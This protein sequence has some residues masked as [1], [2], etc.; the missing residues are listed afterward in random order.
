MNLRDSRACSTYLE[1]PLWLI[2]GAF[3]SLMFA[4]LD[5]SACSTSCTT[6][7]H[8]S[9]GFV[10]SLLVICLLDSNSL[11][12]HCFRWLSSWQQFLV[13]HGLINPILKLSIILVPLSNSEDKQLATSTTSADEPSTTTGLKQDFSTFSALAPLPD[14]TG[15][16]HVTPFTH[17]PVSRRKE[18]P[19]W[20]PNGANQ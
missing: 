13:L 2:A 10:P 17:S 19:F 14:S 7:F 12:R 6:T 18:D 3:C 8:P 15:F 20:G 11:Q 9:P 1:K 5:Y 16:K 4:L